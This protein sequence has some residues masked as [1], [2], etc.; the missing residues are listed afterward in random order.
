MIS[1]MQIC[2]ESTPSELKA[3][4]RQI[5]AAAAREGLSYAKIARICGVHSSQVSRIC[6]GEF[7]RISQN[8]LQVCSALGLS[9]PFATPD[10][11]SD[12]GW[13]QVEA[14]ARRLWEASDRDSDR[15]SRLLE[16]IGTFRSK[17]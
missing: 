13:R 1:Y 9:G 15:V 3:L 10:M 5:A 6:R 2:M 11:Q 16:V 8:V 7:R 14:S 12:R 4:K 17:P